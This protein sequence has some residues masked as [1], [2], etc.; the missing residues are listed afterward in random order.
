MANI[1]FV[2]LGVMGSRMAKRL[3]D[4]GHTVTGY[5]GTLEDAVALG[6]GNEMAD[7][8]RAVAEASEITFSMVANTEALYAVTGG[9]NG[10]LAGL[11]A[12]K[13]YIDMSTVSPTA[14]RDLASQV[15]TKGAQMLDSLVSGSVSTLEEGKLSFMVGGRRDTFERYSRFSRPSGRRRPMSVVTVLRSR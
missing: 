11:S 7:R 9:A 4:A 3:L 5:N 1:G 12:G 6:R 2:G 15:E 10:I 8:P 14:S 13:I